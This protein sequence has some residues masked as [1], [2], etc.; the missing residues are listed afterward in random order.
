[1]TPGSAARSAPLPPIEL[2]ARVGPG[3]G[4]TTVEAFL[5]EGAA[6]R[7]RIESCSR[8]MELRRQAGAR[9]RLRLRPRSP[10]VPG[11]GAAGRVLGLRHRRAEHRLAGGEPEPAAA[12][13]P[14]R[15][16]PAT[17]FED[18]SLDLVWAMS[19]FTHIENWSPWLLE[20]HRDPRAGGHPDRQL[21]GRGHVG[22]A[23]REPYR[24]D[25]V[26]MTVLRHWQGRRRRRPS[27]RVV[28]ARPLG[29]WL[30]RLS[31][32]HPPRAADGSMSIAHS[33]ITL[34]KRPVDVHARRSSSGVTLRSHGSWQPSTRPAG[35]AV[36]DGCAA[37]LL[38]AARAPIKPGARARF[39]LALRHA[40]T[41]ASSVC[42]ACAGQST[43]RARAGSGRAAAARPR[44]RAQRENEE[45]RRACRLEP[46][47]RARRGSG[48]RPIATSA[49]T[50]TTTP[51]RGA[52]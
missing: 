34:R 26:G 50:S 44:G 33:Y 27:F 38:H 29:P 45:R 15:P 14:E 4:E 46:A 43:T 22:A 8:G 41:P 21:P 47:A 37:L 3:V 5:N 24:E 13:L 30:R 9:L 28:A 16:R 32:E 31:V 25:E 7:N 2:A 48:R 11:R 40:R 23:V 51:R 18:G 39:A 10:S 6:A 49:P 12:L 19:V 1:M 35:A 17:R 36:R 42:R 52:R 20:M